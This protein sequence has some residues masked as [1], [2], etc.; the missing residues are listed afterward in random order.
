MPTI[1]FIPA[2][3]AIPEERT[4]VSSDASTLEAISNQWMTAWSD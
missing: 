1:Q 2:D 3:G 4:T